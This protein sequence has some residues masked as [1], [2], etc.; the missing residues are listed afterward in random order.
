MGNNGR[1]K[2]GACAH[3]FCESVG[4]PVQWKLSAVEEEAKCLVV[5]RASAVQLVSAWE[6]GGERERPD[7]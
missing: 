5:F 2:C 1:P 6:T 4:R 7:R 3:G